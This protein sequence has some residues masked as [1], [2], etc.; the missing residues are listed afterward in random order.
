MKGLL[1]VE[2][3]EL[4]VGEARRTIGLGVL[5]PLSRDELRKIEEYIDKSEKDTITLEGG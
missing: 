3:R 1:G 2:S 5:N 4:L